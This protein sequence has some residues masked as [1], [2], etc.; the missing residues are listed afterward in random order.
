MAM[1][2]GT[3][4]RSFRLNRSLEKGE[5]LAFDYSLTGGSLRL[6]VNGSAIALPEQAELGRY[7]FTAPHD[8]AQ[9]RR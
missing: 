3:E 9:K 7:V 2:D 5:I 1:S 8:G 4:E 6:I